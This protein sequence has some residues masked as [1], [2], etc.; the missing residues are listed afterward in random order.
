MT[1]NRTATS[2][3]KEVPLTR[4]GQGRGTAQPVTT[5]LHRPSKPDA[6]VSSRTHGWHNAEVTPEPRKPLATANQRYWASM[7]AIVVAPILVA[8]LLG[9]T[10][11]L[12]TD[13]RADRSSLWGGI[14]MALVMLAGWTLAAR[15]R[16]RK[17][18]GLPLWRHLDEKQAATLKQYHQ[19]SRTG[20][21]EDPENR[22]SH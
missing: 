14:V 5:A 16:D 18:L 13:T 22:S 17:R 6:P 7:T 10:I 3:K 19:W 9:G 15:V 2:P 20:R 4:Q 12:L 21:I 1:L 11:T 8:G